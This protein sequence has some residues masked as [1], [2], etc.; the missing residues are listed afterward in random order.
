MGVFV[1]K[2]AASTSAEASL[3]A[4]AITNLKS[5]Y[6]P[7]ALQKWLHSCIE[8]D[9]LTTLAYFPDAAPLLLMTES[10]QSL[11][12]ENIV[13]VYLAGAY[14]LDPYHDLHL[15]NVP[16]GVYRLSD[17]APDNF[18]R[19]RYFI[20]YYR[21]TT[22]A[23]EIGFILYPSESVSLH[24]CL[25][26][27]SNS[28]TRFTTKEIA[29]AKR[30]SP[31]VESLAKSHWRNLDIELDLSREVSPPNL[32]KTAERKL[33]IDLSPRQAEVAMLILQGHSSPSIGMRLEISPQTVKVFRKQLYKKC[34][35]S[36]QA[37]LFTLMLPL[38]SY[39]ANIVSV[40]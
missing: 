3:L 32:V 14:L 36:S 33:G 2:N 22:L 37:E 12:H 40:S 1:P 26:K 7:T 21:K 15:N 20:E 38:I 17:I 23:D 9:N 31:I 16:A 29:L 8:Y 27:D 6:F 4:A 19:S 28:G 39:D 25:G 10:Q 13:K 34:Q 24:I 5:N 30:I 18:L 11:T 35:I